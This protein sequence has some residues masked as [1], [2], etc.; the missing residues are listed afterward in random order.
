MTHKGTTLNI[1]QNYF[2]TTYLCLC[3]G[4]QVVYYYNV[5]IVTSSDDHNNP[6]Y[7]ILLL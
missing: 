1:P 3:V 4:V 6:L 7:P 2:Y 5:S